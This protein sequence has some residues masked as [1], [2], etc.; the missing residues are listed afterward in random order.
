MT[1]LKVYRMAFIES[2]LHFFD[3][4][5]CVLVEFL[6]ILYPILGKK[7]TR[8]GSMHPA[9]PPVSSGWQ[10]RIYASL[11]QV[12]CENSELRNSDHRNT[13]LTISIENAFSEY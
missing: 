5:H 2:P 11:P 7:W 4:L 12:P 6:E 1:Y 9:S 10:Q 8:H 13:E 3:C